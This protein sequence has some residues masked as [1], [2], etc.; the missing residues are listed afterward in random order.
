[1]HVRL[2]ALCACATAAAAAGTCTTQVGTAAGVQQQL[3]EAACSNDAACA[4]AMSCDGGAE[5]TEAQLNIAPRAVAVAQKASP[6]AVCSSTGDP[7][8]KSFAKEKFDFQQ[9]GHYW[10]V[11]SALFKVQVRQC[12]WSLPGSPNA[13][14]KG[15]VAVAIQYMN[16]A[17]ITVLGA[18]TREGFPS[19]TGGDDA[20]AGIS[21]DGTD[22]LRFEKG[23]Y[24]VRM[25]K[26]NGIFLNVHVAVPTGG[27]PW[28]DSAT[29]PM[30][31]G[32]SDP[33]DVGAMKGLCVSID[34][35]R[36]AD[37][38]PL[39]DILA[40]TRHPTCVAQAWP[41]I[42]PPAPVVPVNAP[43]RL[44]A[45]PACAGAGDGADDCV[46][47]V[48]HTVDVTPDIDWRQEVVEP[49]LQAK[50]IEEVLEIRVD[51]PAPEPITAAPAPPPGG[52]CLSQ[53]DPHFKSFAGEKF[54]FQ[55]MGKHWLVHS[56]DFKVQVRQCPW[57]LP[58]SPNAGVRGNVAIAIK[59]RDEPTITVLGADSRGS[60]SD[61]ALLT[62]GD[63]EAVE[64]NEWSKHY[65]SVSVEGAEG[66][67]AAAGISGHGTGNVKFEKDG[68]SVHMGQT[69]AIFM[70]LN[71]AV[72]PGSIPWATTD[73]A[74]P[75]DTTACTAGNTCMQGLCVS[76]PAAQQAVAY[77]G[78]NWGGGGAGV[79][80]ILDDAR[81]FGGHQCGQEPWP[82][83]P[84][85]APIPAVVAQL[86]APE[87]TPEP[88]G[89]RA[90][91]TPACAG[92]GDGADDCVT[93]VLFTVDADPQADWRQEVVRPAIKTNLIQEKERAR[94]VPP[95]RA[96]PVSI[97]SAAPAAATTWNCVRAEVTL[98][99]D[100]LSVA[101]TTGEAQFERDFKADVAEVLAVP[102]ARVTIDKVRTTAS[103][104]DCVV[105]FTVLP[106]PDGP[107][108]TSALEQRFGAAPTLA[109]VSA[110]AARDVAMVQQAP[111]QPVAYDVPEE[112]WSLWMWLFVLVLLLLLSCCLFWAAYLYGQSAG[113]NEAIN[114]KEFLD[115]VV[116]E[117]E[118]T[119]EEISRARSEMDG[120]VEEHI[121]VLF[122][123]MDVDNSGTLTKDEIMKLIEAEGL[124]VDP[125][126]VDGV[127]SAY[128][129]DGSGDLGLEEFAVMH[130]IIQKKSADAKLAKRAN[131]RLSMA[132][133]Y[134][135]QKTGLDLDRDGDVGVAGRADTGV[136]K[137]WRESLPKVPARPTLQAKP[138]LEVEMDSD[139]QFQAEEPKPKTAPPPLSSLRRG[140]SALGAIQAANAFG[141]VGLTPP[142]RPVTPERA[143]PARPAAL[144]D[145]RDP[146]GLG[147]GVNQS[148][149]R[150]FSEAS[151][152]IEIGASV[153]GM[154]LAFNDG[155]AAGASLSELKEGEASR[156]SKLKL[157]LPTPPR[158]RPKAPARLTSQ[159][160]GI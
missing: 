55:M 30:S 32:Q 42:L 77:S 43:V 143:A 150:T 151:A 138:E 72:P 137:G 83:T 87:A 130:R 158:E 25:S 95:Q 111:A 110:S 94:V 12:P 100:I 144:T 14:V 48:L 3:L 73:S 120:E 114:K 126:Y 56:M 29:F 37:A 80:D 128:D 65:L 136:S 124:E 135:E 113:R 92:A 156:G 9:S 36:A 109:G 39:A 51:P 79:N 54:D 142:A 85:E 157:E 129:L 154:A 105:T 104:T 44:Q 153:R 99:K 21:G 132:V 15:N 117:D 108:D 125:K 47:D 112:D 145:A 17:P 31:A 40:D 152:D 116:Q 62:Q 16:E 64:G 102:A 115:I 88:A 50:M 81:D 46:V 140:P 24:V 133:N 41:A 89:V 82:V 127:I 4:A 123:E 2:A 10:L 33:I 148:G 96:Q 26:G 6:G 23:G 146:L 160:V 7:H 93:D 75:I 98:Q 97:L 139:M 141:A 13:G 131:S 101:G 78:T 84:T 71:V 119:E 61:T 67:S 90:A 11:H 70:N 19:V 1:M 53:G 149:S 22:H 86:A 118:V 155:V 147:L 134:M 8:F 49:A 58:N 52:V 38:A 68:F 20:A 159:S 106:G 66:D 63:C 45:E 28:A 57:S 76:I 59:Y 27:V 91:A 103:S 74:E 34:A 107:Y 5:L 69:N 18:D 60:C 122:D 121:C 35:A